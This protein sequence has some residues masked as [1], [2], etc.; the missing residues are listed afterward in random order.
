[1]VACLLKYYFG[2]IVFQ[3]FQNE[4]NLRRKWPMISTSKEVSGQPNPHFSEE[5]STAILLAINFRNDLEAPLNSYNE[6]LVL[7]K[8]Q[9]S[10]VTYARFALSGALPWEGIKPQKKFR[11]L[12]GVQLPMKFEYK[13]IVNGLLVGGMSAG[14]RLIYKCKREIFAKKAPIILGRRRMAEGQVWK[15]TNFIRYHKM[16]NLITNQV[17]DRPA[18]RQR[19]YSCSLYASF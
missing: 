15:N 11:S 8:G 19:D 14:T 2:M 17:I 1:M 12:S 18:Q 10:P 6:R 7:S 13:E 9:N 4:V 16:G 3:L 5:E